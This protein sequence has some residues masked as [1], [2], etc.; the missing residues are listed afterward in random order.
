VKPQA[1]SHQQDGPGA[2]AKAAEQAAVRSS[3]RALSE[4]ESRVLKC[5]QDAP[6]GLTGRQLESRAA[7]TAEDLDRALS[8]LIE[9]RLV[10]RLNTIIPSYSART[11]SP[12]IDGR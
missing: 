8:P 3:Q 12:P 9:R 10:T 7:C 4:E 6:N 2:Q 5:L 1:A 11:V